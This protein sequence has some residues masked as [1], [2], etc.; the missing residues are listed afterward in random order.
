[1]IYIFCCNCSCVNLSY[2]WLASLCLLGLDLVSHAFSDLGFGQN[3]YHF[4]PCFLHSLLKY[5][6]AAYS[7]GQ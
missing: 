7:F 2:S 5:E 3:T 6:V 1:M 4:I